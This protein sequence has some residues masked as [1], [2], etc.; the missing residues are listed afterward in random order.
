M[1]IYDTSNGDKALFN[2]EITNGPNKTKYSVNGLP[3]GTYQFRCDPHPEF[4]LGTF[5]VK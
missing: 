1:A 4:M 3:A 5:T 2:G